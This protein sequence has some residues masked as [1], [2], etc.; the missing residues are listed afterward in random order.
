MIPTS[1]QV[2]HELE[3]HEHTICT[4]VGDQ[5]I[6]AQ[7]LDCD[8]IHKQLNVFSTNIASNYDVIPTHFYTSIF[9]DKPQVS[10]EIYQ[11]IKTTRGPPNFTI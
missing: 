1:I 6:H 9:I 4:S 2:M 7:D 3:N 11:S 5:H 8:E 10:K